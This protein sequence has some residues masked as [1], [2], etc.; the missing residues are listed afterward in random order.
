VL[1]LKISEIFIDYMP[2]YQTLLTFYY[3]K[4]QKQH[5]KISARH[6]QIIKRLKHFN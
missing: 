1:L 5:Y 2:T 6:V 3:E 4:I